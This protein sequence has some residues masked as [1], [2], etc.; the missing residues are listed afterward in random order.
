[1]GTTSSKF[2]NTEL[3]PIGTLGRTRSGI[4]Y[5]STE[6]EQLGVL[7]HQ[8][9]RV[10]DAMNSSVP[11][12]SPWTTIGEAVELMKSLDVGAVVVCNGPVLVGTLSDRD[13]AL[14]NA[15]RSAAIDTV[16]TADPI[17]CFEN[18]L[19]IDAQ[20]VIRTR[21]LTA[22]PVQDSSGLLS[23]IV[24]RIAGTTASFLFLAPLFVACWFS[25]AMSADITP[26]PPAPS[27]SH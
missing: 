27:E 14:A 24:M 20:A 6:A 18:D 22:L 1:M 11:I 26:V 17:Y 3:P 15:P 2:P 8:C 10:K 25:S 13:I 16:M 5:E 21:G 7:P 19:L 12:V 9:T 4:Y 23:G